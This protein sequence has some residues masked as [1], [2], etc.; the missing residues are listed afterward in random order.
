MKILF[1]SRTYPP[2]I[3]GMEKLS[4]GLINSVAKL[5]GVEVTAIVNRY[6]KKTLPFFM[7]SSLIKAVLSARKYDVIH[8]SDAVLAP[9]GDIIKMFHPKIKVICTIHGLDITYGEKNLFYKKVNLNALNFMDKI[10]AVSQK[11][12]ETAV[13]LDIKEEKIKVI[14]CGVYAGEHFDK[15]IK[16]SQVIKLIKKKSKRFDIKDPQK[17]VYILTLGRLCK[18]KGIH[19]FIQNV[20]PDLDKKAI[21]LIAGEGVEKEKILK[22]IKKKKLRKR[23]YFLGFVTEAEKKILFNGAQIFVQPNIKVPGDMEG[24]GITMIEASLC[25]TVVVASGIEGIKEAID[26]KKNGILLKPKDKAKYREVLNALIRNRDL[27]RD[28][29]KKFRLFSKSHFDWPII[30]KKYLKEFKK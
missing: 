10:I 12:K 21:Y 23:V 25:R 2:V 27:R 8:L 4:Y 11:T 15:S 14:P 17:F 29:A 22:S 3:G 30:A 16:K 7:V 6:G 18:R 28:L 20:L 26:H 24:F 9:L 13:N 1:I 19:W 5:K